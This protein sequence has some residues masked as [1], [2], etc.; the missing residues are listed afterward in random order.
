MT[1][2]VLGLFLANPAP[3]DVEEEPVN[4]DD[5]VIENRRNQDE[6]KEQ[7]EF[8]K[9]QFYSRATLGNEIQ[10]KFLTVFSSLS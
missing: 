9:L 6:E 8:E 5:I 10:M 3:L 7:E 1:K 4:A 2:K